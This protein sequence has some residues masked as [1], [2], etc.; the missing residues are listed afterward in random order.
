MTDTD[1]YLRHV[2]GEV[3]ATQQ[4]RDVSGGMLPVYYRRREEGELLVS[5]SVVSLIHDSG[6]FQ[7]NP[8]FSPPEWFEMARSRN[9]RFRDAPLRWLSSG[10][11][12]STPDPKWYASWQTADRR[13]FKLH[14]HEK[15][16]EEGATIQFEPSPSIENT[17]ELARGTANA[18]SDGI[19]RI[20]REYPDAQHVVLTGGRDSMLIHLV[21]KR[22]PNNW[23]VFSGAPNHTLVQEWVETNGIHVN[24]FHVDSKKNKESLDIIREKVIGGDLFSDQRHIRWVP[25]LK[26][27]S[28]RYDYKTFFWIGT[29]GDTFL[30]YNDEY[31]GGTSQQFWRMQ[32]SRAPSW[33]GNC[34][35][36][37]FNVIGAPFLSVYHLPEVREF[38]EGFSVGVLGRGEDARGRV[39][40]IL[41]EKEIVWPS[42]NPGPP[43]YKYEKD[44]KSKEMYYEHVRKYT[45]I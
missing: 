32:H 8:D 22:D 34:H 45:Q 42:I 29:E 17:E 28:K 38:V 30:S 43:P 36:T 5:S 40:S 31:Q 15:V 24:D 20:E 14:P 21:P 39:A 25:K 33:Q 12:Y 35:Q 11:T 19:R 23:H 26:K 37:Y 27:I 16:T 41:S 10:L 6:E 18:M 13:V 3:V 44:V 2:A 7:R 9:V 4:I 1:L